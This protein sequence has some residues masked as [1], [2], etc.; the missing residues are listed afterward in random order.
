MPIR[1]GMPKIR[2]TITGDRF[3]GTGTRFLNEAGKQAIHELFENSF[4][5][6]AR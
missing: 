4:G 6:I 3:T 1:P 2:P 5:P